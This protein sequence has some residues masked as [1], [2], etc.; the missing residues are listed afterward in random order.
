M[1]I[2]YLLGLW[3]GPEVA[4]LACDFTVTKKGIEDALK[5]HLPK[6]QSVRKSKLAV[7]DEVRARGGIPEVWEKKVKEY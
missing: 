7:I 3:F 2:R 6:G 1:A 4:N 5:N